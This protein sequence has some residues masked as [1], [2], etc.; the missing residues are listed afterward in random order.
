MQAGVELGW[1]DQSESR[2]GLRAADGPISQLSQEVK[3][4]EATERLAWPS[5]MVPAILYRPEH[6]QRRFR[7]VRSLWRFEIKEYAKHPSGHLPDHVQCTQSA[8]RW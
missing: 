6:A 1:A 5:N 2:G 3:S 8:T 7:D 4:K